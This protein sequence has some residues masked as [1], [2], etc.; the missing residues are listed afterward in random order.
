LL[1]VSIWILI[2]YEAGASRR[3]R[4]ASEATT[5]K[6]EERRLA[7]REREVGTREGQWEGEGARR[8]RVTREHGSKGEISIKISS[9]LHTI[10]LFLPILSVLEQNLFF[11]T[12]V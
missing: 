4:R 6:E 5:T 12:N 9:L 3:I 10:L 1:D 7:K 2:T 11:V 8:E